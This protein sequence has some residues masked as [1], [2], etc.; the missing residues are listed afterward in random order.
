MTAP[1]PIYCSLDLELTGFDPSRDTILEVGFVFFRLTNSGLEITEQWSQTFKPLAPVHPKILGLTGLSQIEL[2]NSPQFSEFREFIQDKV[3]QAILVGHNIVVDATFLSAFGIQLSDKSIDTLDLVQWLLPTHHSYNLEN[4]MHYFSIAHPDAHRA[5]ADSI[6]VVKVLEQLL[7][8][9]LQLPNALQ[10]QILELASKAGFPWQKLFQNCIELSQTGQQW[11]IDNAIKFPSNTAKQTNGASSE[12]SPYTLPYPSRTVVQTSFNS[13][14]L[15]IPEQISNTHVQQ[16]ILA[17]ADSREVLQLW[18]SGKAQGLFS[19]EHLFDPTK[20]SKFIQKPELSAEEI[21]FCFKI[22]VWQATN[23]QTTTILDLNLTFFGG[24]FRGTVTQGPLPDTEQSL[25]LATNF[26]SLPQLAAKLK[27]ENRKVYISSLHEFEKD[28]SSGTEHRLSWQRCLYVL[29][30][31]DFNN[32]ENSGNVPDQIYSDALVAT[33]LFFSLTALTVQKSFNKQTQVSLTELASNDYANNRVRRAAQNYI[34]KLNNLFASYPAT[35][36]TKLVNNLETFFAEDENYIKWI[37][38]S[39]AN[40]ILFNQPLHVLEDSKKI[41]A[42]FADISAMEVFPEPV[43]GYLQSRLGLEEFSIEQ[44]SSFRSNTSA[45]DVE[46]KT[47]QLQFTPSN[48]MEV[49]GEGNLPAAVIMNSLSDIKELYNDHYDELKQY[50]NLYAQGYSGGTNKIVR[51]FGINPNS[52]LLGTSNMLL[53]QSQRKLRAKVLVITDF[54]KENANHPYI[55]ALE[56]YWKEQF[57]QIR[58]ILNTYLMY[59]LLYVCWH[60][61]LETVY[62]PQPSSEDDKFIFENIQKL[63]FLYTN[64]QS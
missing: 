22:L 36:V 50:S 52:I 37:E 58:G 54:P 49:L 2:D 43:L 33:D 10:T 27:T 6:A 20:F 46:N 12:N 5:L 63:P 57:P 41:L 25:L 8:L 42:N 18:K 39:G 24:Q 29:R 11:L 51:N 19:T 44:A 61:K 35:E 38:S 7:G 34:Q 28:L 59:R 32:K 40:C 56:Q 21:K 14:K 13:P 17:L 30:G 15:V 4:L 47:T 16:G 48:L 53:G 62:V 23:W 1:E 3:G 55:K 64:P 60:E 26:A 9:F 45:K 31:L